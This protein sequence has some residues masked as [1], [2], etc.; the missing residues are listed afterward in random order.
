MTLLSISF[1]QFQSVH[2]PYFSTKSQVESQQLTLLFPP[3]IFQYDAYMYNHITSASNVVHSNVFHGT[4]IPH[5]KLYTFHVWGCLVYVLDP[6]ILNSQKLTHWQPKSRCS[7]FLGYSPTHYSDFPLV[8][9]LTTGNIP[10]QY[11]VVLMTPSGPFILSLMMKITHYSG[12][13]L[14]LTSSLIK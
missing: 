9:N 13:M 10:P 3:L 1:T 2:G 4:I 6:K 14:P 11:H 12:T 8:L 5:N 7:I